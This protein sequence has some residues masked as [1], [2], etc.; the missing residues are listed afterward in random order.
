M[1]PPE[2]PPPIVFSWKL[3]ALLLERIPYVVVSPL[4]MFNVLR[5][6]LEFVLWLLMPYVT[7]PFPIWS[8]L[9]CRIGELAAVM[10]TVVE[11]CPG[12]GTSPP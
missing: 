12:D 6:K 8:V 4:P 7:S 9:F 5:Q 11:V 10:R 3:I 1:T 2:L